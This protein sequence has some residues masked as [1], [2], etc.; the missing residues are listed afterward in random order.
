MGGGELP[1][2]ETRSDFDFMF[3]VLE[4]NG[5]V[6]GLAET[7]FVGIVHVPPEEPTDKPE[8]RNFMWVRKHTRAL[9]ARG[10]LL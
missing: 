2:L 4:D 5:V 9:I 1:N 6:A 10:R 3:K 7:Y 8:Y